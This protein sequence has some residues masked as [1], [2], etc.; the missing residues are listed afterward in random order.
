MRP[1][2]RGR[3]S[4]LSHP[5]SGAHPDSHMHVSCV[6]KD[7]DIPGRRL[8]L[9][10]PDSHARPLPGC[11]P[12]QALFRVTTCFSCPCLFVVPRGA[13]GDSRDAGPPR[14]VRATQAAGPREFVRSFRPPRLPRQVGELNRDS[15]NQGSVGFRPARERACEDPGSRDQANEGLDWLR[16]A[17][18]L[19]VKDWFL[20]NPASK[21]EPGFTVN[22]GLHH[23]P[24]PR[25]LRRRCG[26]G[27]GGGFC[28]RRR[29]PGFTV[30]A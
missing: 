10:H 22:P 4:S 29:T 5:D 26:N 28:P 2:G 6:M 8:A 3:P 16:Q 25:K 19:W 14:A 12:R 17:A 1:S 11:L 20:Q 7:T 18:T 13:A 27:A 23:P 15:A 9:S 21:P 30:Y 24:S